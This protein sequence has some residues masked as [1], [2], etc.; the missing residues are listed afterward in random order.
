MRQIYL[1]RILNIFFKCG[2]EIKSKNFYQ[3][4]NTNQ[5]FIK[6]LYNFS[7][8]AFLIHGIKFIHKKAIKFKECEMVERLAL[9]L[10]KYVYV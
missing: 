2:E 9:F 5:V 6:F 7:A 8:T 1:N 3:L 10:M 4:N